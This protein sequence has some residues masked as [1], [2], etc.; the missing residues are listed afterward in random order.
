M[1]TKLIITIILLLISSTSFSQ[2]KKEINW[3]EDLDYMRGYL[4]IIHP[5][6]YTYITKEE[7]DKDFNYV[8]DNCETLDDS[9]IIIRIVELFAKIQDGHTGVNFTSGYG[10]ED[11]DYIPR[12]FH[13]Y[14]L[15]LYKFSDGIFVLWATSQYH[16]LVGKKLLRIGRLDIDDAVNQIIRF[17]NGD[18]EMGRIQNLP[19]ILEFLQFAGVMDKASDKLLLV[20]EDE[21]GSVDSLAITNPLDVSEF[22]TSFPKKLYPH[23]DSLVT[24]MNDDC[25]RLLP[26][27]LSHLDRGGYSGEY[28]WFEYLPDQ[29]AMY[30]S[31]SSNQNKK[32]DPFETFCARMFNDLDSLKAKKMIVD[33]RLNGGGNHIEMPLIKGII[34]RPNI[35]TKGNLFLITSRRTISGSEHL[36]TQMER[37]TNVT[38]YGEPTAAK[39]NMVGSLTHFKLPNSGLK[40]FCAKNYI[41]D[42]DDWDC[43]LTTKPHVYA[44]L[45]SDDYRN[46]IDPVLERIFINDSIVLETNRLHSAMEKGYL[47][48]GLVGLRDAYHKNKTICED[49]GVNFE[50]FLLENFSWWIWGNKKEKDDYLAYQKFIADEFPKST[51]SNYYY[52]RSCHLRYMNDEAVK[53]YEKSLAVNPGNIYSKKYLNLLKF[54]ESFGQGIKNYGW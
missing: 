46:N 54:H 36:T 44:L 11:N 13:Y 28:Y 37:Y 45:S 6:L 25:P 19:L 1:K 48:G 34:A 23:K 52:A 3:Q 39:P 10:K 27:Y 8:K 49:L 21:K 38:I 4:E 50:I 40:C 53:Y 15:G 24:S 2:G 16:D 43:R 5:A 26:Q 41:Q 18:N 32:D 12:L 29:E 35:D 33:V 31:I 22:I 47:E 51:M 30:V 17:N 42:S 20:Y 7:F 14:P 9:E